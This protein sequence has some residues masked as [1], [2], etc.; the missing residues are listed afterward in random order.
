MKKT[1][2]KLI[3]PVL[4]IFCFYPLYASTI[5]EWKN[6]VNKDKN[7]VINRF[8]LGLAYYNELLRDPSGKLAEQ[9]IKTM[10]KVLE[11]ND[12]AAA[13]HAQ[14]D[15]K[16]AQIAGIVY[17]NYLQK[18]KEALKYF[19]K[20]SEINSSD[21]SNFYFTGLAH[22]RMN[23]FDAAID[24][25]EKSIAKGYEDETAARFRLGQAFYNKGIYG[26][27]I[28]NFRE[29]VKRK[30][31]MNYIEACEL[32][33][34][35]YHRRNNSAKA[36]ENFREVV[37][38][39]PENFNIQY[40]LG[41]N[42]FKE[43]EYDRMISAYRKAIMIN[44]DFAD[45][46]YNLGMAYYYR[47]LY[48]EAIE[49]LETAK[50]LNPSD[51]SVYSLLAQ[52]K[53]TAYDYYMSRGSTSLTEENYP[54]AKE[55]FELALEVK[56][57]DSQAISYL[58]NVKEMIKKEI[59]VKL[60]QAR[61]NYKADNH[62]ESYSL[63]N[64]VLKMD[65]DNSRAREGLKKIEAN[66]ARLISAKEKKAQEYLK[67]EKYDEAIGELRELRRMVTDDR[68]GEVAAKIKKAREQR[69]RAINK[70]I[71]KADARVKEQDYRKG[72][73]LYSDVLR[74][75]PKNEEALNGLTGIN[76]LIE[77]GISKNL[78]YARQ[79][80]K[81]DPARAK[82]YYTKVLN[83]DPENEKANKGIKQLTGKTSQ[84]KIDADKVKTLYYEGV[85]S[86]VNGEI[87][88]AIKIWKDVIRIDKGHIEAKRN[89]SRA[90]KKLQAIKSLSR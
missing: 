31:H 47:N 68:A 71:A 4:L 74:M 28:K 13:D 1:P 15:F 67:N 66:V 36:I 35:I 54:A 14:V 57:R 40:L 79:N 64:Y 17:Y 27:A 58:E 22:I 89:I 43:K 72:R 70:I 5:D 41:L 6:A 61:E 52:T 76:R 20:A 24:A 34:L 56:P 82:R 77:E 29:V 59:P 45:A 23:E 60:E 30:G 75:D 73:E 2:R 88:N 38:V 84:V 26:D 83:L 10:K 65:P 25:F 86:Y 81:G 44:P 49:E 87:E 7:N 55:N 48:K 11:M 63:W 53:D 62:A 85:D 19:K 78:A 42:Y 18:D 69:N 32:L 12:S 51:A 16:A 33:G 39:N 9:T 80:V 90:E 50:K 8:N 46:H 3:V 37:K 21:G